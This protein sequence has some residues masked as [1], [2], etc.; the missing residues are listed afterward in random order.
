MPEIWKAFKRLMPKDHQKNLGDE[1]KAC[2][3][4]DVINTNIVHVIY[5]NFDDVMRKLYSEVDD[6]IFTRLSSFTV[7]DKL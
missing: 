4:A 7:G 5:N 2:V 1:V 3:V 6:Y